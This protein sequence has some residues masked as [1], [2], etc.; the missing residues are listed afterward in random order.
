[1][2]NEETKPS[3]LTGLETA[4]RDLQLKTKLIRSTIPHSGEIGGEVEKIFQ[5][6]LISILPDRIGVTS[7]FVQD[8]KGNCSRQLDVILFDRFNGPK[9]FSRE[10]SVLPSEVVYAAG[11]IKTTLTKSEIVDAFGKSRSFKSLDRGAQIGGRVLGE[12]VMD[13]GLK[14]DGLWRP[15]FF[16]LAVQSLSEKAFHEATSA[17]IADQATNIAL[18]DS[19]CCLD[20]NMRICGT[21]IPHPDP[22]VSELLPDKINLVCQE[23]QKWHSYHASKPWALFVALLITYVTQAPATRVNMV[24]YLGDTTF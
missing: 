11:E 20:G 7:G 13:K 9:I 18:I 1:M 24:S 16:L 17:V 10:V 3:Y 21:T 19:I 12:P 6:A 8:S 15:F 14:N 5:E 22:E 2:S 23:N 4:E